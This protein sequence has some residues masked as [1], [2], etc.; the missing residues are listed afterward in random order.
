M[1]ENKIIFDVNNVD[2]TDIMQQ[3]EE[4]VKKRKYDE[5]ALKKLSEPFE[6]DVSDFNTISSELIAESVGIT[7]AASDVKYWWEI[8]AGGGL[9]GK[10]RV[11]GNKIMRKLTFFYLKHVCDQQN[12]FNSNA[13]NSI[14]I[15]SGACAEL[16]SENANLQAQIRIN[17]SETEK[18]KA[19][20]EKISAE[21]QSNLK[22][23]KE[24]C[25]TQGIQIELLRNSTHAAFEHLDSINTAI[26]ARMH[27]PTEEQVNVVPKIPTES[28]N[29][30]D[31]FLFESKFRGSS[32]DIRKRQIRYLPYFSGKNNVLDLGCGRGEFLEF[33][34]E[35]GISAKGVDILPENIYCCE[36]KKLDVTLGDGIS[37]L[38]SCEDGS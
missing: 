12:I 4:N 9:K 15:L 5:E 25:E 29:N 7:R 24:V 26:A 34:G 30:F 37:Y 1:P 10:I 23:C 8:P 16:R 36:K 32:E 2:I 13:A 11:L 3:I 35:N 19:E 31:Y 33:L 38:S 21:N 28:K 20:I 14:E 6:I 27:Q 22:K 17:F 18:L